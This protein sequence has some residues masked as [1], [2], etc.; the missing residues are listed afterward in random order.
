MLQKDPGSTLLA[1]NFLMFFRKFASHLDAFG[2]RQS[3]SFVAHHKFSL[4]SSTLRVH[5][6][7]SVHSTTLAL[8]LSGTIFLFIY[9][10]LLMIM[11]RPL[12]TRTLK[13][14]HLASFRSNSCI[15]AQDTAS[16]RQPPSFSS[17]PAAARSVTLRGPA[18][19]PHRMQPAC[20]ALC[21]G[22]S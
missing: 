19:Q 20:S 8:S 11:I 4:A 6:Q 18:P 16:R 1:I 17:Q 3:T 14:N 12:P 15:I 2:E 7:L 22:P 13:P 10:F 21:S 9:S 5:L